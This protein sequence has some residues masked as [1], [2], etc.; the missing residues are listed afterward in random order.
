[1]DEVIELDFFS[2][3]HVDSRKAWPQ[4]NFRILYCFL[5]HHVCYYSCLHIRMQDIDFAE[6]D[7]PKWLKSCKTW[8]NNNSCRD[9]CLMAPLIWTI[10]SNSLSTGELF[11]IFL[12]LLDLSWSGHYVSKKNGLTCR[13]SLHIDVCSPSKWPCHLVMYRR[14]QRQIMEDLEWQRSNMALA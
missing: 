14:P 1:M 5:F 13:T 2:I 8:R 9:A 7:P 6:T 10:G 3:K 4:E 11:A 12:T